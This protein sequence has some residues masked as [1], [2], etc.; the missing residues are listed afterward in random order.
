MSQ[1]I[2]GH[3]LRE[4][5]PNITLGASGAI[6]AA[7]ATVDIIS[8]VGVVASAPALVFTLPTP[9]DTRSGVDFRVTNAGTN[10]FTIGAK[11]IGAS[12]YADFSFD[13][14]VWH[15]EA[16]A[17]ADL[18]RDRGMPNTLMTLSGVAT[19]SRTNFLK[20]TRSFFILGGGR[21]ASALSTSGFYQITM[22][23][24]GTVIPRLGGGNN[25]TVTADGIQIR[26]PSTSWSVLYYILNPGG[27]NSNNDNFRLAGYQSDFIVP[28]NWVMIA[29]YNPDIG[30]VK[31]GNGQILKQ[32]MDTDGLIAP[33]DATI[34][35][36]ANT[37]PN[38]AG[39]TFSPNTPAN[40]SVV[41]VSTINGAQWTY[42]G[43][44]Y[45]TAPA[46]ADWK[47]TGNAATN[48][49]TNFV[50]TVD[51]VGLSFRTNNVIRQT[52]TAAGNVIMGGSTTTT[53][54]NNKLHVINAVFNPSANDLASI[55]VEGNYGGGVAF[56]EGANRA[57]IWSDSGR[58][59]N[60]STG[61]TAAGTPERMRITDTG[62]V[63]INGAFGT[64]KLQVN[65]NIRV[66]AVPNFATTALAM[67]S[68][69]VAGC[70]YTVTVNG[71]KQLFLK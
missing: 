34:D 1:E 21:G 36:S 48:Q 6:G 16:S 52:I 12:D 39:T 60:F 42:N 68:P 55:K 30:T 41:Y 22:P 14:G 7:S 37:D 62:N 3:L 65:G 66:T 57:L 54:T 49:A 19:F 26:D 9:T 28:D 69:L 70:M 18:Y 71:A 10:A 20:W 40:G 45:I 46:S 13:N 32:G 47:T 4:K 59:L 44:A 58:T 11:L 35:F 25:I 43:T 50:G 8:H 15:S 31:L 29:T 17:P 56:A 53:T 38:T 24:V 67:V 61:G 51:N 27:S 64:E 5:L 2:N 63:V 33:F 23:P